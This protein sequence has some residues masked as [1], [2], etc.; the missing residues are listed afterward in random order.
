MTEIPSLLEDLTFC[1][2]T[3]DRTADFEELMGFK[4]ENSGC[5][6]MYWR[7]NSKEF[8]AFS[9]DQRKKAMEDTINSGMSPGIIAYKGKEPIGWCSIAPKRDYV[10]LSNSRTIKKGELNDVWSIVCFY[11][12]KDYRR[13]G[14]M[15]RLLDEAIKYA[16]RSGARIVEGY[17]VDVEGD[18]P[19][20]NAYTGK[21]ATFLNA[22]FVEVEGE[23]QKRTLVR[24]YAKR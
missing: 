23:T 15:S 12:H 19:D 24:Y 18:V 10:R 2:V 9:R 1:E 21:L 6:C 22:G 16:S 3:P 8:W 11:V 13:K 5:W 14:V 7:M 4:G 20:P 17:P